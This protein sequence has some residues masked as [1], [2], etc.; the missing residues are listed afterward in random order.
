MDMGVHPRRP[1]EQPPH[2]GWILGLYEPKSQRCMHNLPLRKAMRP[3]LAMEL[4]REHQ[5]EDRLGGAVAEA[6]EGTGFEP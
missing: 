4:A 5:L 6:E 2:L 3:P 1:R